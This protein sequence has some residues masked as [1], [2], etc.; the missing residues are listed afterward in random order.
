MHANR[1]RLKVCSHR[2]IAKKCKLKQGFGIGYGLMDIS[3]RMRHIFK[4][5]FPLIIP[6]SRYFVVLTSK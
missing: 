3:K 2:A 4:P 6:V 1:K 5:D